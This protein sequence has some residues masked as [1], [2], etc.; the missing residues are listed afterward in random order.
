MLRT[1]LVTGAN[2]YIGNGITQR[3]LNKGHKVIGIDNDQKIKWLKELKSVSA[4]DTLNNK[5]EAIKKI[6]SDYEFFNIDIYKKPNELRKIF[7][8]YDFDTIINLAQMPSAPYSQIDLKHASWT[9]QNNTIGTLN[10]LWLMKE[11]CPD[12]HFIEIESMGTFMPHINTD[13]PEGLFQFEYNGRTSEPCLFPKQSGSFYHSCYSDDTEVLTENGWKFFKDLSKDEKIATLNKEKNLLEYQIPTNHFEY[14]FDGEL[15][16]LKNRSIDLLITDNHKI[17]E[18][19]NHESELKNWRLTEVKDLYG[20]NLCLRKNVDNFDG[21]EI[22]YFVLPECEINMGKYNKIEEKKFIPMDEWLSFFGWYISEGSLY[23]NRICI[24]QQK[25]QNFAEIE[26]C[27]SIF[28]RKVQINRHLGKIKGFTIKNRQLVEYLKQFGLSSDKFIPKWIK[29]LDKKSLKILFDSLMKGDGWVD[30]KSKKYK[31]MYY[32]NSKQLADDVQEICLKLGYSVTLN[33]LNRGK[34]EF[35][36]SITENKTTQITQ[37]KNNFSH[38]GKEKYKG[39]I[40]CLEVPND[41]MMVR[42]NGKSVWCGNSKL[43]NTYLNDCANRW[44]NLKSTII[45]QGVVYGNYTDE[46]KESRIHSHLSVDE[47]MGTCVNRFIVQ[48]ML[49]HPLTVYGNGQQKRGYLSLN[50]SVQC[51]ELFVNNPPE[52]GEM[53]IINQLDEIFTINEIADKII[54]V[55]KNFFLDPITKMHIDSPRVEKT[56]DFYYNPHTDTLKKLGFK[57]TRTIEQ[58]TE[59]AFKAIN[60]NNLKYL[61]NLVIPKINWR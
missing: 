49:N 21:E 31:G 20:C 7:E 11:F 57:Q 16:S 55:S 27:L 17:F 19:T 45:N 5:S 32:T 54:E 39:K 1:I 38:W 34:N 60:R 3:L 28:D 12:A 18:H 24:P 50:D 53:R 4:I 9:I 42:R 30:D 25:E 46:I 13:I 41:I 44:W 58:E 37:T 15:I 52:I 29:K 35:T 36:V 43:F 33:K 2:G 14:D 51:L 59:F 10:I 8:K 22:E 61:E 48:A 26:K 23:K 40:Y 56:D 47:C 6:W